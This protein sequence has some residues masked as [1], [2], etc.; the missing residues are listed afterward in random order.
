MQKLTTLSLLVVML[1]PLSLWAQQRVFE[2]LVEPFREVT[3]SSPVQ[4]FIE[5]HFV[6]EGDTVQAGDLLC[7][8]FLRIE[9]LEVERSRGLIE[10]REFDFRGSQNLF[11]DR[12][13]SED[14]ALAARIELDL[15]RLQL[16]IA[17]EN[18]RLREIRSP[19]DGIIVERM[20]EDGETVTATEPIFVVVNIEQIYVQFYVRAEDLRHIR[21]GQEASIRFPELDLEGDMPGKVEFIDP[22]VDAASGLLRV[23]VLMDNPEQ[24]VK[25]GVR[26]VVTF[27]STN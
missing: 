12:L 17:E 23:R 7:R 2:G 20:V 4:S 18:V 21:V 1:S 9:Q 13:I 26:A 22:R 19:I 15:A 27:S 8:L 11:A 5:E 3:L 25:A 16:E 6:R 14:E 10:K 24:R